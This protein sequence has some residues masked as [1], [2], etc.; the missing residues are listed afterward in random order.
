[1]ALV[2]DV[3]ATAVEVDMVYAVEMALAQ[4]PGLKAVE[5]QRQEVEGGIT[6]ARADAF[7]QLALISSWS[8]SRNPSLL[9]SPDFEEFL[10][11][12]PAG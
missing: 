9:N 7:P 10:D 11:A 1:V 5:E 4:N 6:E 12:F 3:P 2:W 8:R